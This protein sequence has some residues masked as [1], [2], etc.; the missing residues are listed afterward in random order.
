MPVF[1]HV[2]KQVSATLT[3][4][5]PSRVSVIIAEQSRVYKYTSQEA[6]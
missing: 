6:A 4:R 1:L 2:T 3:L 5:L